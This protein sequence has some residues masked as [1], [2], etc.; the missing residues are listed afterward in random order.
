MNIFKKLWVFVCL[1]TKGLLSDLMTGNL[2]ETEK[3]NLFWL[4]VILWGLVMVV[5][6]IFHEPTGAVFDL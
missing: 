2:T 6:F 3:E 4:F 1:E 5:F